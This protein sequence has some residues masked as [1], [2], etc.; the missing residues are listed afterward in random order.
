MDIETYCNTERNR[1]SLTVEHVLEAQQKGEV[2]LSLEDDAESESDSSSS[3]D[4]VAFWND[5][6]SKPA[7]LGS[8]RLS[9]KEI[10]VFEFSKQGGPPVVSR[11]SLED[12]V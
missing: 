3:C 11:Q 6:A 10:E 7:P 1:S 8:R 2:L 12:T 5:D 4:E 9:F